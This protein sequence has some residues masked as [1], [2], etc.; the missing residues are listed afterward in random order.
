MLQEHPLQDLCPEP[1]ATTPVSKSVLLR[2]KVVIEWLDSPGHI[3]HCLGVY[4]LE[5]K[6]APL[7]GIGVGFVAVPADRERE[8]IGT[9]LLRIGRHE[10]LTEADDR[11][12][13]QDREN[14]AAM[15]WSRTAY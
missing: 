10:P 6:H 1:L 3:L 8:T 7:L 11:S 2:V 13:G 4:P 5:E 15:L 14:S 12:A 9:E